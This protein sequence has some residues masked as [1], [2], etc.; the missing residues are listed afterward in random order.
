MHPTIY[1]KCRSKQRFGGAK[2]FC[3][4]FPKLARKTP[5]IM[6]SK[7]NYCISSHVGLIFVNQST[8]HASFLPKFI[9]T[10]T[11]FHKRGRKEVNTKLDLQKNDC[12]LILCAILVN[13][14]TYSDFSNVFIN[15]AQVSTY[16]ARILSDF[17][18]FF[19]KS[20]VL[21]VRFHPHLL[22][23]CFML[24]Y[25][26]HIIERISQH[27]IPIAVVESKRCFDQYRQNRCVF[28]TLTNFCT[29]HA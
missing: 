14:N 22:H 8:L 17:S 13:S 15:F 3:S 11:D 27:D 20:K 28:C 9:Q 21:G 2:D 23:Q 26:S 24:F 16:F 5:M 1:R 19:S 29:A 12:T 7:N 25:A 6:T 10:C 18:R 4:N